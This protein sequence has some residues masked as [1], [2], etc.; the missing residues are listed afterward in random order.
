MNYS[1]SCSI[2]PTFTGTAGQEGQLVF[3]NCASS[4]GWEIVDAVGPFD[5]ASL[6]MQAMLQAFGAGFFIV[7]MFLAFSFGLR[8]VLRFLRTM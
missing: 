8:E 5:P 4:A 2:A 1:L 3:W 7:A 6:D